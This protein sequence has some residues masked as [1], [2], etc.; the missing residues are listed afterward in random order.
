MSRVLR[1][2]LARAVVTVLLVTLGDYRVDQHHGVAPADQPVGQ[3]LP[4]VAGGLHPDDHPLR[5]DFCLPAQ[6][7]ALQAAKPFVA[8]VELERLLDGSPHLI[9]DACVVGLLGHLHRHDQGVGT[10]ERDLLIGFHC[11]GLPVLVWLSLPD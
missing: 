6:E 3:R 2:R 5:A 1:V 8:V 9:D 7:P 11:E 4:V 10:N